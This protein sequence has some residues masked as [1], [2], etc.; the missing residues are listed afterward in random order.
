MAPAAKA[1]RTSGER[2]SP[3]VH[4][5]C[6]EGWGEQPHRC[7]TCGAETGKPKAIPKEAVSLTTS[8]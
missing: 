2:P 8:Q 3:Q 1:L 4:R 6:G 5:G 7:R